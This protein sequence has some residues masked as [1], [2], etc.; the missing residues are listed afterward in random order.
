[1]PRSVICRE[2]ALS[3]L[4]SHQSIVTA[5]VLALTDSDVG[6]IVTTGGVLSPGLML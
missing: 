2:V 3:V 6:V 1:V 5:S 4:S